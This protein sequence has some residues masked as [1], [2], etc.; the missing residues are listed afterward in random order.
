MTS[1]HL[2]PRRWV[3]LCIIILSLVIVVLDSTVL[4]VSIPTILRELDT[5]LPTLQWVLTGYSLTFATFLIIGGRLGDVYGARR[6]FIIGAALFGAGSLL[7][8]EAH[9]V[10][11]LI[12]G[13]AIIEGIGASLMMPATLAI[14]SN[15]FDGHERATAF[16]IWGA[17]S[18]T[19]VAFGPV[20]GGFL[21]TN[22]SWRW[23][24]RINVIV[25][26]L[27]IL[28]AVLFMRRPPAMQRRP[29]VDVPGA[30]LIGVGTFCAVFA[31]S[32]GGVYGWLRPLQDFTIGALEIWPASR[33][34]SLVV[35]MVALSILL[36]VAFVWLERRK[37]RAASDPLFELGQL[38]HLSFRYGLLTTA[39]L[40]MGQLGFLFVLPVLLQDGGQHL[41]AIE[42]GVWLVPSGVCIA[43]GAQI[44]GRLTRVVNTTIVVRVGL[45]A[46]AIGLVL[47]ALAVSPS[48]TFL[49]LLP[50]LVVFSIGLGFASSQLTN[51][52]LSEI[53]KRHAGAASGANTTVRQMG[54]AL[55]IAIIGSLLSTQMVRHASDAIRASTLAADVKVRALDQLHASGVGFAPPPSLTHA[56]ESAVA[57]GARPALLFASFVVTAGALLSL[58]IPRVDPAAERRAEVADTF[59]LESVDVEASLAD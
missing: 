46:E 45:A 18:G 29:R 43:A 33:P 9:S 2:D 38:R 31:L 8:S 48:T 21:T 37:E 56:I 16:S 42:T 59:V 40:A 39:V 55:G 15:T 57:S 25:A 54:A 27:A 23:A 49:G 7:A 26:P 3:T 35:P 24:F 19:A 51:V 5:E 17:A 30:A 11:T 52:V 34:V 22:Y 6:M 12:V 28:G 50:G 58:L 1:E 20:L 32:E 14:L 41:S 47:I 44:G 10:T 4:N 36:L 13:E 53:D